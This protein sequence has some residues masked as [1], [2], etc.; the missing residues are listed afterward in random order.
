MPPMIFASVESPDWVIGGM[1]GCVSLIG[2]VSCAGFFPH[3]FKYNMKITSIQ[4]KN[5]D[6]CYFVG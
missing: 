5:T 1:V 3:L 4:G 2:G 6:M